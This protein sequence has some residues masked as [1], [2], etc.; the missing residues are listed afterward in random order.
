[1]N[2]LS[3]KNLRKTYANGVVAIN[4]ISLEIGNA[5]RILPS[6]SGSSADAS[7]PF[8]SIGAYKT[9]KELDRD[10]KRPIDR[11]EQAL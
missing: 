3:I 4:N 9:G 2:H 6:T 10:H 8:R 1:M 5:L 7:A 11:V